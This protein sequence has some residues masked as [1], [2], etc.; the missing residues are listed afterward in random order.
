MLLVVL[1]SE[2]EVRLE[3]V[4]DAGKGGTWS[5]RKPL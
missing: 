1:D 2:H 5:S 4:R 3:P